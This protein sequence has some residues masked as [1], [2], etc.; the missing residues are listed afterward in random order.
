MN[1][2]AIDPSRPAARPIGRILIVGY[3]NPLR[4]D[5]AFGPLVVER[6]RRDRDAMVDA[7]VDAGVEA[8][9]ETAADPASVALSTCHQLVPELAADLAA[10]ERVIFIDAAVD[11]PAG[12]LACRG[13]YAG[14]GGPEPLV[15][16]LGPEQ[17]LGL[18]RALYGRAPEAVLL[19]VGGQCFDLAD[20]R[21]SPP[22]A[23]AVAPAIAW[24][25]RLLANHASQ[26]AWS[27]SLRETTR[28]PTRLT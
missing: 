21:L 18:T 11:Q 5:D 1:C 14:E 17:L 15:H 12:A 19:T 4:G 26:Q 22:V 13:V 20:H 25:Q 27:A 2:N 3:G 28:S 7:T 8:G 6:L 23:A 24:I 10:V 9:V 16:R